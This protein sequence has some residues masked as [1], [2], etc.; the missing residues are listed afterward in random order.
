MLNIDDRIFETVT[1]SEFWLMCHI[2]KRLGKNDF[3]WPSNKL[4]CIDTKWS[5]SKLQEVKK[6]CIKKGFIRS[7]QRND[8]DGQTTNAYTV[9]TSFLA[10]YVN[11]R[12]KGDLHPLSENTIGGDNKYYT[13]LPENTIPPCQKSGNE[14]LTNE[15]LINEPKKDI[16]ANAP[17]PEP[18]TLKENKKTKKDTP[19]PRPAKVDYSEQVAEIVAHLNLKAKSRFRPDTSG[20]VKN[21]SGRLKQGY[22]VEDFKTVIDFKCS[23]W[24]HDPKMA[25]YLR[26]ETLFCEKHFEGYLNAANIWEKNGRPAAQ[27]PALFRNVSQNRNGVIGENPFKY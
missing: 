8:K 12:G 6:E 19:A 10:V 23:Q 7:I 21:I 1:E 4:L 5:L 3:C 27:S 25:E 16:V 11:L 15:A 26:P 18:E 22:T 24:L 2:A 13:P 17:N 20:T 9:E 14:V